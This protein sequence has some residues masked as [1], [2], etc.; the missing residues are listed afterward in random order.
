M[1]DLTL[2]IRNDKKQVD[3]KVKSLVQ[4]ALKKERFWIKIVGKVKTKKE[5]TYLGK[6][7]NNLVMYNISI[8]DPIVFTGLNIL[9]W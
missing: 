3:M 6:V 8:G 2:R 1:S 7:D 5:I 4:I 9:N